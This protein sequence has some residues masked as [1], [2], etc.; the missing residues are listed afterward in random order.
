M[1]TKTEYPKLPLDFKKKWLKALRSGEF[2]QQEEGYLKFNDKYCCLGVACVVSGVEPKQ[3]RLLSRT[4]KA[5]KNIPQMLK[6][7][8]KLTEKLSNMNDG[9]SDTGLGFVKRK[10]FKYIANWI[11]KNL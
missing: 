11:E 6:G 2:K 4:S 7:F 9:V 8:N 10:T 5:H 1:K 3:Q